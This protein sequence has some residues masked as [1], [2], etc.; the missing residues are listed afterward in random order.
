MNL[1][2]GLESTPDLLERIGAAAGA[3]LQRMVATSSGRCENANGANDMSAQDML[4]H[5]KRRTKT[6]KDTDTSCHVGA[7]HNTCI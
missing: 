3:Y 5:L 7:Y 4:M 6:H 2:S 1:T